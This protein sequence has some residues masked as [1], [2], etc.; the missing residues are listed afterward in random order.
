MV[1][2]CL[3]C[4]VDRNPVELLYFAHQVCVSGYTNAISPKEFIRVLSNMFG[5]VCELNVNYEGMETLVV[6]QTAKAA[7]KSVE[8]KEIFHKNHKIRFFVP[9]KPI[10]LTGMIVHKGRVLNRKLQRPLPLVPSPYTFEE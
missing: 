1:N 4:L 8:K 7:E 2:V 3:Y 9:R 5:P 10:R 6:F